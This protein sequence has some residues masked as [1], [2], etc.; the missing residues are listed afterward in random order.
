MWVL[1]HLEEQPVFT[2]AEPSLQPLCSA[3]YRYDSLT[4]QQ[5]T[6]M[7]L[8]HH[9]I[10][11]HPCLPNGILGISVMNWSFYIGGGHEN[12]PQVQGEGTQKLIKGRCL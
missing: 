2:R 9:M 11:A 7:Y 5:L 4:H 3:P 6:S 10:P 1:G 8:H 12:E